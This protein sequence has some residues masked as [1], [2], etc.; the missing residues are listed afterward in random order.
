MKTLEVVQCISIL[1]FLVHS[2]NNMNKQVF[3]GAIKLEVYSGIKV[4]Q[5]KI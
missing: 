2:D 3:A 4:F 1:Y 5:V